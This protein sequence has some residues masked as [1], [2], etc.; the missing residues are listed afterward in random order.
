MGNNSCPFLLSIM[1]FQK[2]FRLVSLIFKLIQISNRSEVEGSVSH[3]V[4]GL[5]LARFVHLHNYLLKC[6]KTTTTK[7][8]TIARFC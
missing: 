1:K 8:I 3:D 6:Q 5:N 7:D 2:Q 4:K